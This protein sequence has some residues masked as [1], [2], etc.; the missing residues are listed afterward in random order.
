MAR[1]I[2]EIW[3]FQGNPINNVALENLPTAPINPTL[4]RIYFDTNLQ[5]IGVCTDI[6]P[7]V[8]WQYMTN[9]TQL[10]VALATKVDYVQGSTLVSSADRIKWNGN[11]VCSVVTTISDRDALIGMKIGDS[12]IVQDT[13]NNGSNRKTGYYYSGTTWILD[14]DTNWANINLSW[15]NIIDKPTNLAIKASPTVSG[16]ILIDD[17]NGNPSDSSKAFNDSGTTHNDIWDAA[18]ILASGDSRYELKGQLDSIHNLGL[19]QGNIEDLGMYWTKIPVDTTHIQGIYHLCSL[20][21]GIVLAGSYGGG[22]GSYIYRSTDWGKTFPTKITLEETNANHSTYQL[23]YLGNGIVLCGFYGKVNS[24]SFLGSIY[25]S[26]DSGITWSKYDLP[27]NPTYVISTICLCDCGNGIVLVGSSNITSQS[28]IWKSI[29][30]GLTFSL[31]TPGIIESGNSI[32]CITYLG[33]G[34]S[35]LITTNNVYKTLDNGNT[36]TNI[37]SSSDYG[38]FN[39]SIYL[40]Q[41]IILIGTENG[42][43]LRTEDGGTTFTVVSSGNPSVRFIEYIGSG[44][45]LFSTAYPAR[46]FKSTDIGNTWNQVIIPEMAA[47]GEYG[48][49][50]RM[51]YAGGGLVFVGVGANSYANVLKSSSI[52]R[53]CLIEPSI[54]LTDREEFLNV[55]QTVS[56]IISNGQPIQGTLTASEIVATDIDR[57][58]QSLST[59]TYPSLT[60]LSYAKG[61]TSSIQDQLNAKQ[62]TLSITP[63]NVSNKVTIISNTSTDTQYPSAKLVYD[64]FNLKEDKDI[65]GYTAGTPDS[66]SL[67]S[68]WDT[69]N[70]LR[71]KITFDNLKSLFGGSGGSEINLYLSN[72]NNSI[73]GYKTLSYTAD[74]SPVVKTIVANNNTVQGEKYLFTSAVGT[75]Q[76]PA[77]TLKH[78]IYCH[79]SATNQG[80]STINIR[81]FKYTTGGTEVDIFTTS[82]ALTNTVD[83]LI[84]IE[85]TIPVII[86][87]PTDIQGIQISLTTTRNT[88]TTLSYTIGDGN[89]S[90]INNTLPLRHDLL[91]EKNGSLAYQHI[92]ET[93]TK[94][95]PIDADGLALWDSVALKFVKTP[96]LNFYN[97]IKTK[98]DSIYISLQFA[99][100]DNK[101]GFKNQIDTTLTFDGINTITL[102]PT[103]GSYDYYRAGSKDHITAAK[104]V[105]MTLT[106]G[107]KYFV[108]IDSDD[109]TLNYSTAAWTLSNTDTKVTVAC[110]AW[111]STLT[112]KYIFQEE[113]HNWQFPR[114]SHE[115]IHKTIGTKVQTIGAITGYTLNSD[116]N[117]NKTFAIAQSIIWDEGIQLVL[118]ELVQPNGTNT[119]YFVAYRTSLNTW[120][121]KKSNMPF[122][123]NVGNSNN[124]I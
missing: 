93:T 88:D 94:T 70:S 41:N 105:V 31:V 61:V 66:T 76:I 77:G 51:C 68:W 21:N 67:F 116:V 43:V 32:N 29:D 117:A 123:Y 59:L 99:I 72:T 92:D 121:W 101:F 35:I 112:P 64:Q 30:Y 49:A 111:N 28:E 82:K 57:K 50:L 55:D 53:S 52:F 26:T 90:Y 24:N 44:V 47:I 109:A 81:T 75:A 6:E 103:S 97:Y 79:I 2:Y 4:G 65:S 120:L 95:V 91:R 84:D 1:L 86:C 42:Y 104:T 10:T 16:K 118:P 89:S 19:M 115:Y 73:S 60:E 58:L 5:Q 9:E 25:R 22:Y 102:A 15:S 71:K 69:L 39:T 23:L 119:D 12:C 36:F 108:Y 107:N 62:G 38:R 3:D 17:G 85:Y 14:S 110:L 100:D 113:R 80:T 7:N 20:G 37:F 114:A 96:C 83:T 13:D 45:C 8:L 33:H 34:I 124:F 87:D 18:Q 48:F 98:L 63:E 11:G 54:F 74:A 27:T 106:D 40:G 46:L 56:Q 78:F 122:I